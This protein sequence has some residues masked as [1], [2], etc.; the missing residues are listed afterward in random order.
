M[1]T[2]LLL[3]SS[4]VGHHGHCP[5]PYPY[6]QPYFYGNPYIIRNPTPD[7][8]KPPPFQ[9]YAAPQR[10]AREVPK[11]EVPSNV[12]HGVGPLVIENPYYKPSK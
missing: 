3:I 10:P 7:S 2:A 6:Y 5:T 8:M 1:N 11:V 4:V 9:L 12:Y